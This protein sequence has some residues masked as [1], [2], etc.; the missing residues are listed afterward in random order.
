MGRSPSARVR[1]AATD[2]SGFTL[3]EAVVALFVLG[4]IFTA[5]AY[6]SLGSLRASMSSRTEQQAIDF[7]TQALE[8]ARA[9]EYSSLA[10]RVA[11]MSGDSRVTLRSADCSTAAGTTKCLDVSGAGDFEPLVLSDSGAIYP[12]VYTGISKENSNNVGLHDRTRTSHSPM[13]RPPW[14]G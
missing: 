2:E 9:F 11:D 6:A 7:A 14:C 5:L 3:V 8:R 1:R 4:I 12:H 10:N 13:T